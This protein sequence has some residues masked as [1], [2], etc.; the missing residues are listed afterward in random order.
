MGQQTLDQSG[1]S[2]RLRDQGPVSECASLHHGECVE[3]WPAGSFCY[4]AYV[5]DRAE[6]GRLIWVIEKSTGS[7]HLF[8][9]GDPV[10]LHLI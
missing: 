6:D 3:V 10:T 8:I 7:R 9:R 2:C 5:D 4:A 1:E